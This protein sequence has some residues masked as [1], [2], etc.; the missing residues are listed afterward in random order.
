MLSKAESSIAKAAQR[1]TVYKNAAGKRVPSVTTILG[2]IAKPA[3]I[4]WANKLG[5]DGI[6]YED[7]MKESA[8]MG[9]LAHEIIQEDLGG[10]AF[11]WD[12]GA[13]TPDQVS[14]ASN[15]VVN[16]Q[17]WASSNKL[18]IEH[19]ELAV[20]NEAYQYGG[21]VDLIAK[22]GEERWLI[23][24]KTGKSGIFKEHEAQV[25]AYYKALVA[26]G[27]R[28][29]GVRILRI[30]RV[31]EGGFQDHVMSQAKLN[32]AWGIFE[33]A[34]MLYRAMQIHDRKERANTNDNSIG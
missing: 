22:L 19:I 9:T 5:L 30:A 28:I 2:V 23:D 17:Q 34:L 10:I 14:Q 1:H 7:Y 26:N 27:Y 4:P 33:S 25:A 15:S 8:K 13:Y 31:D 32:T 6:V 3:L 21:R 16:F 11:Q 18:D 24:F 12:R 20:I 29:D